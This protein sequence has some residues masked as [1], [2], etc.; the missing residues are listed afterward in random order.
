MTDTPSAPGAQAPSIHRR[1]FNFEPRPIDPATRRR[2]IKIARAV[3]LVGRTKCTVSVALR[4][5][6][7]DHDHNAR[8]DVADLLDRRNIPRI[9]RGVRRVRLPST[10]S[11]VF[12][13]F[14]PRQGR[15]GR[16]G[17]LTD[18]VAELREIADPL[19]PSETPSIGGVAMLG[20]LADLAPKA[21]AEQRQAFQ[22]GMFEAEADRDLHLRR[23]LRRPR[24]VLQRQMS[25]QRLASTAMKNP[26]ETLG[27]CVGPRLLLVICQHA[28][29]GAWCTMQSPVAAITLQRGETCLTER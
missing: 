19:G 28:A 1:R 6:G 8:E 27:F 4:A 26:S 2:R 7:L 25:S 14:V 12:E 23:H 21:E 18:L 10:P 24:E 29:T 13:E 9:K 17:H 20:Q 3:C 22:L 16:P 11:R 5:T 15:P